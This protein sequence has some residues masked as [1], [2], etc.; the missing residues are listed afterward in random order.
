MENCYM[1]AATIT[2]LKDLAESVGPYVLLALVVG[3]LAK[4]FIDNG[5]ELH[6]KVPRKR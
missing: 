3:Y 2:A 1:N 6:L 4:S 5:F